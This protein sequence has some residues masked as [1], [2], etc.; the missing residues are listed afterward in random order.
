[1]TNFQPRSIALDKNYIQGDYGFPKQYRDATSISDPHCHPY[2]YI[3]DTLKYQNINLQK[4]S[5][6]LKSHSVENGDPQSRPR[7]TSYNVDW[8]IQFIQCELTICKNT[9]LLNEDRTLAE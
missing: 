1:M 4:T 8:E 9:D 6:Q 3:R 2:K 7:T 5:S